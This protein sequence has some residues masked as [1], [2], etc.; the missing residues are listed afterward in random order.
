MCMHSPHPVIKLA[1]IYPQLYL[2]VSEGGSRTELYKRIVRLGMTYTGES[3]CFSLSPEDE[4]TYPGTPYGKVACIYLSLRE[5]FISFIRIMRYRCEP[6]TISDSVGAMFISG[7]VNWRRRFAGE[8]YKDEIIVLSKGG[9]SGT[10]HSR[11]PYTRDKWLDI[12]KKIRTY[13]EIT[14]FICRRLFPERLPAVTEEVICDAAGMLHAF[15]GYDGR[16][17]EIFLGVERE[18][19]TPGGRLENYIG[20]D[21]DASGAAARA[22]RMIAA[23]SGEIGKLNFRPGSDTPDYTEI[24]RRLASV[25]FPYR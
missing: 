19:L 20:V 3:T 4:L 10:D 22:K 15:G 14:H 24:I 17:A 25:L 7:I 1:E 21:E 18:G 12:S 2:P 16:L 6:Y 23:V 11:T 13:H 5:D 9:Y 8:E